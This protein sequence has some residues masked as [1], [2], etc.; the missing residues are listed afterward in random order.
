MNPKERGRNDPRQEYKNPFEEFEYQMN[1]IDRLETEFDELMKIPEI[2]EF[3]KEFKKYDRFFND[4]ARYKKNMEM[5]IK[6][7]GIT[8]EEFYKYIHKRIRKSK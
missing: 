1:E 3:E 2:E 8:P 4:P 7:C 6:S 5:L